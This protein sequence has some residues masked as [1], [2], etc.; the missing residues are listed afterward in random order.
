MAIQTSPYTFK[1]KLGNLIGRVVDGKTVLQRPGGFSSAALKKGK[2]KKYARVFENAS[3]FAKSTNLAKALYYIPDADM[4][5]SHFGKRAFQQLVGTIH[6]LRKLDTQNPRGQRTPTSATLQNLVNYSFNPPAAA[7]FRVSPQLHPQTDQS[8]SLTLPNP[9]EFLKWP[10]QAGG[11]ECIAFSV[12]IDP[13]FQSVIQK[14]RQTKNILLSQAEEDFSMQL[15]TF[16]SHTLI[17]IAG[18]FLNATNDQ[19][20]PLRDSTYSPFYIAHWKE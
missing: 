10:N 12:Q 13:S 3:E 6:N 11:F 4:M 1:G 8:L 18:R 19:L 9:L 16:P 7:T 15:Q 14:V 17:L 2:K 20:Y 5:K